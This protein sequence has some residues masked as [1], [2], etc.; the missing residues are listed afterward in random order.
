MAKFNESLKYF[1]ILKRQL[2]AKEISLFTIVQINVK[3]S[4]TGIKNRFGDFPQLKNLL[5]DSI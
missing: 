2:R 4:I 1:P 5:A 3:P